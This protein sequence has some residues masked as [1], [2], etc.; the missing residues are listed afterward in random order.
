MINITFYAFIIEICILSPFFWQESNAYA[1]LGGTTDSVKLDQVALHAIE[2]G[3]T[4]KSNY[5]IKEILVGGTTVRE[6]ISKD[7]H[8]FGIAWKGVSHP[9]L[10]I[11]LGGY[12]AG[13]HRDVKERRPQHRHR[14]HYCRN[15]NGITV[16]KWGRMRKNQGRAYI[17]KLLPTGVKPDEIK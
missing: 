17:E 13:Y 10:R 16:Q 11:L 5:S 1:T 15:A 7:G 2:K 14:R 12:A 6:Y 3:T 8:I 4:N 9:N